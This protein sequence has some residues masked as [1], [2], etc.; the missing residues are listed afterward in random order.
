MKAIET[1]QVLFETLEPRLTSDDDPALWKSALLVLADELAQREAEKAPRGDWAI[2]VG[3]CSHWV[4]P[5]NS[6]WDA[7]GGFIWPAGYKDDVPEFDWSATFLLRDGR[8]EHAQKLPGK[9]T[10]VFRVA[11]PARTVRHKQAVVNARWSPKGESV[12]Y[13]F[14]KTADKWRCVAASDEKSKGPITVSL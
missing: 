6:R 1:A 12:L 10:E 13:G 5:H 8:L 2:V 7:A 11:I 3:A 4:R 9:R 14:R